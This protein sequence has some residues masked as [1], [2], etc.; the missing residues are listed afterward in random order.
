MQDKILEVKNLTLTV[1][2]KTVVRDVSFELFPGQITALV[3]ESGSGKT[4][5]GLS[6][7]RLF[8]NEAICKNGCIMFANRNIFD[9][10]SEEMRKI[11]GNRIS[12]VFQEPFTAMNPVMCVGR[13]ISETIEAHQKYL[14][15]DI[16]KRLVELVELVCLSRDV[17]S[18]YPHE[19]SG[20][21]RQRALLAMMIACNPEILI[22]DEPTTALDVSVQKEILEL[23]DTIRKQRNLSVL[24]ITHDFSVVNMIADS[25]CVMKNGK[26]VEKGTKKSVL[27]NSQHEYTRN[28]I[29]CIPRLGD[30]RRRLPVG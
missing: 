14:R 23:I 16:L 19:L 26:I 28:L 7:L 22:L 11:R 27:Y 10:S 25:V 4:L 30:T 29:A 24:F 9:L 17:L 3:G 2:N 1:R 6:L 21:M 5:T 13:Q 18:K 8:P 15:K 12:M 20:G